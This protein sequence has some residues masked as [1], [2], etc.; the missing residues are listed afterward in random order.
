MVHQRPGSIEP[1]RRRTKPALIAAGMIVSIVLVAAGVVLINTPTGSRQQVRPDSGRKIGVSLSSK[2]AKP[3]GR[4]IGRV[5]APYLA[6]W[7]DENL[8]SI[9]R[10][11]GARYLVL[12]YLT[13]ARPG[14]CTL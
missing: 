14:S 6:N 3:G 10:A 2:A 12:P 13:T 8:A 4:R 11:S 1:S 9:A 7:A 5:Y